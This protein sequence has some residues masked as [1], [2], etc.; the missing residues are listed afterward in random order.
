[1]NAIQNFVLD[2]LH[3]DQEHSVPTP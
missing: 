2:L 3:S 1:M